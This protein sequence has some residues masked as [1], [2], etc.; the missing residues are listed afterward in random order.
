MKQIPG[1]KVE[2]YMRRVKEEGIKS[3]ADDEQV[4]DATIDGFLPYIQSCVCNHDI[5]MGLP[6]FTTI[7]K[8]ALVAESFQQTALVTIDTACLQRQIEKLSARLE[9]THIRVVTE[10]GNTDQFD[11]TEYLERAE[12]WT[13]EI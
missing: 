4:R 3:L 5:E 9:N 13:E 1:E 11:N 8:W 7:R 12:Q 10:P 6:G 2:E